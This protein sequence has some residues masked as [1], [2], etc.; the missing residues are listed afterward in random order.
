MTNIIDWMSENFGL[1]VIMLE[2][3]VIASSVVMMVVLY[4][5]RHNKRKQKRKRYGM[6]K[7]AVSVGRRSAG[8]DD[9]EQGE[10]QEVEVLMSEALTPPGKEGGEGRGV[11]E[12]G[13]GVEGEYERNRSLFEDLASVPAG[14]G[15][16]RERPS[17]YSKNEKVDFSV[18]S[19][20]A[21]E[22]MS[23]FLLDL[24]VYLSHQYAYVVEAAKTT[25]KTRAVGRKA[26]VAVERGSVLTI[27]AEIAGLNVLEPAESIVWDGEP[28]NASFVVNVPEG[29]SS[30]HHHGK[31]IVRYEGVAVAKIVFLI[32]V[33]SCKSQERSERSSN[34]VYPKNAFASYA[35][36]DRGE[37]LSRI[38]GMKKIVPD[39][40]V[41]VDVLSLRS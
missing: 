35:S 13:S 27:Q 3:M 40:D 29:V 8:E 41:F 15:E 11:A 23:T 12:S 2:A 34:V 6:K 38:Q 14:S 16:V 21:I 5:R 32:E 24:W 20:E 26:G 31:I 10:G 37:V 25:G 19:P 30:G 33:A 9:H 7:G 1:L 28:T 22:P 36:Q 18:F 39:L 17:Q 4:V